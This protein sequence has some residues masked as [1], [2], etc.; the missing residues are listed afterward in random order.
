[1]SCFLFELFYFF[2][3]G[4]GENWGWQ[5]EGLGWWEGFGVWFL[6]WGRSSLLS[7]HLLYM[8]KRRKGHLDNDTTWKWIEMVICCFGVITLGVGTQKASR[9]TRMHFST[10]KSFRKE[11]QSSWPRRWLPTLIDIFFPGIYHCSFFCFHL[12]VLCLFLGESEKQ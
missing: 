4:F 2:D 8:Q 10:T 9:A 11:K 5:D 3:Y 1:M 12:F 7:L 6:N